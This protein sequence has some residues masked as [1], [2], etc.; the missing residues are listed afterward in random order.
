[1]AYKEVLPFNRAQD[2]PWAFQVQPLTDHGKM[3]GDTWLSW[4]LEVR[5][6]FQ[7]GH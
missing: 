4:L 2:L 6:G 1:M 7:L 3:L 5:T